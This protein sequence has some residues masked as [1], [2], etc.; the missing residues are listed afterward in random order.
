MSFDVSVIIPT[1]NRPVLLADA[2]RSLAE[3]DFPHERYELIVVDD[4]SQ[5][6]LEPVV[7]R[8]CGASDVSIRLV[9]HEQSKGANAARNS[10]IGVADSDL[11]CLVDDDIDVPPGWLRA[12]VE[13][14]SRHPDVGCLGGP[15]RLRLEGVSA[16]VCGDC[17][18]GES[19]LDLGTEEHETTRFVYSGN[20]VV[21]R[22]ALDTAGAFDASLP[23]HFEEVE[24]QVRLRDSGGTVYYLPDAWL[25]HRRTADELR[26][27]RRFSRQFRRGYG[28]A[29]FTA[30]QGLRF[31]LGRRLCGLPGLLLHSVRRRCLF[32]VLAAAGECG[33]LWYVLRHPD[34]LSSHTKKSSS[35]KRARCA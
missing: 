13:G 6:P 21:R 9:R 18:V 20:M 11:L 3:Q 5:W 24:W 32:G 35:D 19:A 33:C 30:D 26:L 10:G 25:W 15:I 4:G 27:R 14:A 28:Q 12:L 1:R 7:D 17:D 8:I 29:R 31:E 2:L 16:G 22:S 34:A 23:M